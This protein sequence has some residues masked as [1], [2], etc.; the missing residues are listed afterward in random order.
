MAGTPHSTLAVE[1]LT[2]AEA[3]KKVA[4][5]NPRLAACIDAI[6]PP[7]EHKL[8]KMI[9]PFGS[10]LMKNGK[11][12]LPT[13]GRQ[14]LPIDHH[15]VPNS[16]RENLAYNSSSLPTALVLHNSVEL[17]LPFGQNAIPLTGIIEK[18]GLFAL[19]RILS[20]K[21]HHPASTW[22]MTA[23][24]RFLFMLPKIA[25]KMKHAKL[26]KEFQIFIEPPKTWLDHWK[27]FRDLANSANFKQ[28]W[29]TEILCFPKS[30]IEKL[31]D[32]AWLPFY[33]YLLETGWQ[34]SEFWR[35]QFLWDMVIS[36]IQQEKSIRPDP[37][38]ADTVKHLLWLGVGALP[39]FSPAIDDT[40]G[41]INRLKQIYE[42]I[43]QLNS[44]EAIIL[45]PAKFNLNSQRPIYYSLSCPSTI[46]F[47]PRSRQ[48][49]SK[50]SDL[51]DVKQLLN[52]YLNG[53][54]NSNLNLANTPI[55]D[56]PNQV[57]YRFFHTSPGEYS[58]IN[59]SNEIPVLDPYF[60]DPARF[61]DS[62]HFVNGCI[63]I[64]NQPGK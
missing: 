40:A 58:G 43:Y 50:I 8:Y 14:T 42:E 36:Q 35:N 2:W 34:G 19:W 30:W 18:G 37:Y 31:R 49:T 47:S 62:G 12:M 17:F 41:P 44:Y 61:P 23:G 10:E 11:F 53:I 27:V 63:G 54:R 1:E 24:A 64:A 38:I 48:D 45:Q 60:G 25:E 32:P 5:V 22:N 3:R 55:Y 4:E 39:G 26:Q 21:T 57:A 7:K 56:L 15:L 9:Y 29:H 13:F 6:N 59:H 33:H 51:Y 20:L 16:I 52:K 46:E 28:D